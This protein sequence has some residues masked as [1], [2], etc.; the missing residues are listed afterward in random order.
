MNLKN[1]IPFCKK[2]KSF[3]FFFWLYL[4]EIIQ[5]PFYITFD[6]L[7]KFPS[8][9]RQT[10]KK[11]VSRNIIYKNSVKNTFQIINT[12]SLSLFLAIILAK[13]HYIF[14]NKIPRRWSREYSITWRLLQNND[15]L[16]LEVLHKR[17][18]FHKHIPLSN[19]YKISNLFS[20]LWS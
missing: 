7:Q 13:C 11:K 18:Y 9:M 20:K 8:G 3:N 2:I 5:Y 16:Y 15:V 6:I 17:I 14:C 4:T 12:Y 19:K 1:Q 10:N